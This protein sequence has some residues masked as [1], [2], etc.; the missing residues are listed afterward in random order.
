MKNKVANAPGWAFMVIAFCLQLVNLS[1]KGQDKYL[2]SY[3]NETEIKASGSITLA[4]GFYI[5][6]G[7]SVRIFTSASFKLCAPFAGAPSSSQNYVSTRVF[8]VPGVNN[9]NINDAKDICDVSQTVQYFDGLGRAIQTV[10]TQGSP[11]FRD[12][13]QPV[14]YDGFGREAIKYLPYPES[15]GSNGSYRNS[16]ISTQQIFFNNP[17]SGVTAIPN[18]A[19]S[20]TRFE[21]SPFNRVLEQGAPGLNWQLSNG[22]TQKMEYGTNDAGD[23]KLWRVVPDGA[24]GTETYAAGRLHKNTSKDENWK[25]ANGKAGTVDEYKDLE[26]RVVLKRVWETDNKSLSTYY[27]YDN[28]GNLNYVLPP[29]VNQF[30]DR[31]D[32]PVNSF[33][34]ADEVFKQF[35]YGYHYDGRKRLTE[36]KIPGKGWDFMVYNPLDQIVFSQ[37]ANQKEQHTW[38]FSKYDASGRVVMTGLYGDAAD[39]T[40]LQ[41]AVNAQTDPGQLALNKPLWETRDNANANG[42]GTGYSNETLPVSNVQTYH[43]INYYDDYDFYNNTFG[44]PVLPQVGGNRTKTSLTGTRTTTLGT[45]IMLLA[46][47]Y[48]DEEGRVVQIKVSNHLG[49]TDITDNTY[50]F[51]GELTASTLTH[52]ASPGGTAT[53]IVNRY[54]YD[55][56]GRKVATMESINGEGEVVLSKLDY[57]A[58]GQLLTKHLHS[59]DGQTFLQHTGYL[60]NERGWLK[61]SQSNEFKMRLGYDQGTIPQYNGNIASQQWGD[62]YQN[63]YTYSYDHLNRLQSGVS[64]GV[65]M[66]EVLTYD[67]MGNIRTLDRDNLG[68]GTYNYLGNRLQNIINGPLATAA[69]IYDPNGNVITDGRKEVSLT[70]NYLNLPATAT[71]ANLN[72]SYTYDASGNKLTKTNNGVARHYLRGIEYDGSRIDIIHTEEGIARNKSG[73]FS[74]EYNLTDHLGNTRYSFDVY[75]GGLRRIQEQDYYAF[76]KIRDGQYVFGEKNKYLYNGKELQEELGQ[77]DYGARFYDPVIGRWNVIDPLAEQMRR[78]SPYSYAFNNPIRF[79]D[80]DGMK[81]VDDYFFDQFGDFQRIDRNNKRDKLVV[82]NSETGK[83][84]SYD[85]ADPDDTKGIENGTI[86]K[87]TFVS[88]DKITEMLGNAGALSSGNRD[89]K[90]SFMN[91]ESKGGGA[92]DFSYSTIPAEFQKAGASNDPL[93]KPAS[94]LFIPEGDGYV[95]NQMNFGN[96]LW[97]AAG[98]SLGFT[99]MVLK[100]A[101]HYNSIA[102]SS[103]NGY[104]PQFDSADDQLSIGRGVNFSLRQLLRYRTLSSDGKLSPVTIK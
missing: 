45:G 90:W 51:A 7:R 41:A 97:G 71:K 74:Y 33:T 1:L 42:L 102:N 35:I 26:G 79:I 20:E 64:T 59:T 83:R 53:T 77:L 69:Y 15:P 78:H 21:A 68:A 3:N 87:V 93:S 73:S 39:R 16:A 29:A 81:P 14:A 57:N 27:V 52:K 54:E 100:T 60:Y 18:T 62:G 28:L 44:Q 34:E 56:V 46:V 19:F 80:P 37:D 49:G 55:H 8:K 67:V 61:E 76:G 91:K 89:S 103:T 70:Y 85:F 94:T 63:V 43:S 75:N 2:N 30:T 88:A 5:P 4:N 38:L 47:N 50:S 65:S 12:I 96:Y 10:I 104:R 40:T 36:K 66:S 82:E 22:H 23:V 9:S 99:K 24:N 17:L 84:Q 48:Y 32:N 6:A 11:D 95:H 31:L 58:L 25:P 98:Y 86:N 13:V 72:L 101:A 92:L